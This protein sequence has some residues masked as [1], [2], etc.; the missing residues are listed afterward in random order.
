MKR[1][2]RQRCGFGCVLCGVPIYHYDHVAPYQDVGEHAAENLTLLCPTHHQEKTSGLLDAGTVRA[3]NAEPF[4]R[5]RGRTDTAPHRLSAT[6]TAPRFV[7]A[8][9]TFIWPGPFSAIQ[10]H[11]TTL[12][13]FRREDGGLLLQV[14]L[15]D[16]TDTEILTV[17]DGEL[18]LSTESWDIDWHGGTFV[19]R[20]APRRISIEVDFS[21]PNLVKISRGRVVHRGKI[22]E[23]SPNGLSLGAAAPAVTFSGCIFRCAVGIVAEDAGIAVGPVAQSS[24]DGQGDDPRPRRLSLGTP[25]TRSLRRGQRRG[26]D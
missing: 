18:I 17:D 20:S 11:G 23:F 5:R 4:N 19:V 15:F 2:V 1:A 14:R 22:V 10:V 12:L 26:R 9:N 16:S 21:P 13:G 24:T 8:G 7:L 6:W 25:R 3:A